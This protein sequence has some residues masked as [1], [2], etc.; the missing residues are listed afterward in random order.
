MLTELTPSAPAALAE[1]P[2]PQAPALSGDFS[3]RQAAR[4]L[5]YDLN[6]LYKLLWSGRLAAEKVIYSF[7]TP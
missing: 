4:L 7:L 6:Y 1:Q 3:P 2:Q 5:N